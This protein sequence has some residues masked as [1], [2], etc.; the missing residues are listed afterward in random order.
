MNAQ[1][2]YAFTTEIEYR[3]NLADS[4]FG[5]TT[6]RGG[7]ECLRHY[8]IAA[9]GTIPCFKDL[10]K[11]PTKC[12]P[13]GLV[14]GVNCISYNTTQDLMEQIN[15]LSRPAE[16]AMREAALEWAKASSTKLRALELLE[17]MKIDP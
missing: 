5:I 10:A 4:R 1:T 11:K 12:A 3:Q 16:L 2:N 14:N 15:Q 13:Q 6:K 17:A 9:S 7:W 8:E